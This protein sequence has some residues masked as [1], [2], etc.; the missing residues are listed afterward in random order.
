MRGIEETI[1]KKRA[2]FDDKEPSSGHFNVFE[3]KLNKYPLGRREN[4]FERNDLTWKIAAGFLLFITIGTLYYTGSFSNLQSILT[5]R[6][7][8]AELPPEVVEV[9]QYYNVIADKKVDEIDKLA[10]TRDEAT[11]VKNMAMKEL[12]ALENNKKTLE[13]EYEQNPNNERILN[14][15]M[16]NQ[17]KKSEIMDKI[18]NTLNHVN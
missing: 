14:A 5:D 3:K 17:K 9:M 13:K 11:K 6:I 16:L 18:I 8:A 1:R 15:L 7:V 4:W 2:E 10:V 12:L